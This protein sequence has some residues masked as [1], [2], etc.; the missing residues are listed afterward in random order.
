MNTVVEPDSP[1]LVQ[2]QFVNDAQ[3]M[4]ALRVLVHQART[5][6]LTYVHLFNP[7]EHGAIILGE[8]HRYL[9]ALVQRVVD[10][11]A[12][13]NNAV[14]V[15]PQHGKSTMLSVEAPSWLLG[16]K[17]KVA[18]A[19]TGFSHSLVTKFSKAIRG[20][21]EN[22]IYQLIFPGCLPVRGSN[23]MDEWDT[24]WGGSV[25]AKSAGS[26]L[27]GRRVDYLVMDDVHAGRAEAESPVQ[28]QK[29][30]EWYWADCFTRLHPR[31]KQFLIGT[32]WHPHDLIGSLTSEEYEAQ[33]D[34]ENKGHLKFRV[35][36]MPAIAPE[37]AVDLLGRKPGEALFPEERPLSFLE[38][39][40][41]A[42]PK[43]EWDSQYQCD[44]RSASSG[45][46]DLS[47]MRYIA[48]IDLVP[49]DE[50]DEIVRGWD[51]ALSEKQSAD[52]T[53]G[54]LLGV[55]Y[56]SGAIYLLEVVKRRLAW[57][58]VKEQ[59]LTQ[60]RIDTIGYPQ[61]KARN[62]NRV[63]RQGIE[64]VAG[65]RVAVDEVKK[66]LLGE[67]SVEL[68]NPP[69]KSS[70]EGG[71]SK[72]LRAQPWLVKLEKGNM[73][74]VRG[75]WTKDFIDELDNFPDGA[76]DDQIDAVSIAHE[77]VDRRKQLLIA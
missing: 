2:R 24:E 12:D 57:A 47:M 17:P 32:R 19:I 39:V 48:S 29:V 69:T 70:G 40:R 21:L 68:K 44:P 35:H 66:S 13:P 16:R 59:I 65:F 34:A 71:G 31:A 62:R 76:H 10:D 18:L 43:Y 72:L 23:R 50:I 14:S 45:L 3:Y 28:R 41:A 51:L 54:A 30:V 8:L 5:D 27:T 52:Y 67:V 33:L 9:I 60:A 26:K 22:P 77:M 49:W 1:D 42:L 4:Q 56:K 20:R 61:N 7:Q 38:G 63:M 25:V 58:K 53:A 15:P 75:P 37:G 11:E 73:F 36:S 74:C 64:G 46:V 6:F 55:N